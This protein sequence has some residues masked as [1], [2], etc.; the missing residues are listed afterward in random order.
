MLKFWVFPRICRTIFTEGQYRNHLCSL[1][2][3]NVSGNWRIIQ[4]RSFSSVRTR[5]I[6]PWQWFLLVIPASTFS[7]GC[8]Q[9]QRKKWKEGLIAELGEKTQLPAIEL[10]ENLDELENLEYRSVIV[11]GH[12]LHDR[13]I[14]MGPRSLI[15]HGDGTTKSSVFSKQ[16]NTSGYL[17][18]TPLK[19]EGREEIILVNRGWVPKNRMKASSRAEG[20]V[21]EAVELVGIVRLGEARP[22]FTP[23]SKGKHFLYRDLAKMC[24]IT[25][26][27]PYFLDAVESSSLPGGPIGGQTRVT[28][29]NEHLSYI[30][31]WFGLSG[32]TAFMWYRQIFRRK[33]F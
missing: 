5:Y 25:G 2:K 18:V 30:I 27:S 4:H 12:F 31:T 1:P 20:Q 6:T 3:A 21:S 24:A 14:F 7:L 19:L 28:M 17:V 26:A 8:W 29:R 32:G 9:V 11:R 33:A 22:Q 23:E 16:G 15:Q 13:E 10:P